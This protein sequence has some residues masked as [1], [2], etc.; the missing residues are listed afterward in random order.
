[1]PAQGLRPSPTLPRARGPWLAEV[2]A[3]WKSSFHRGKGRRSTQSSDGEC[4][5]LCRMSKKSTSARGKNETDNLGRTHGSAHPRLPA[6]RG[7]Q[8]ARFVMSERHRT[9]TLRPSLPCSRGSPRE[10][11]P[12]NRPA[13][14]LVML[15]RSPSPPASTHASGSSRAKVQPRVLLLIAARVDA[16]V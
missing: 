14:G 1:M 15:A 4:P 7:H 6:H 3:K 8:R 9:R 10:H 2:R 16:V 13:E 11:A 12:R 5:I